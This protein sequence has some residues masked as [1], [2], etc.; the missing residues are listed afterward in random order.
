MYNSLNDTWSHLGYIMKTSFSLLFIPFL[1][2]LSIFLMTA[3]GQNIS[4][5]TITGPGQET[6]TGQMTLPDVSVVQLTQGEKLAVV[7]TTSIIG[8]VVAKVGGAAIQL[9]VLMEAGQDPHSF[10]PAPQD[11]AAIED[12]D[13]VFVNGLD[14]EEVLMESIRDITSGWVVPVS[15]G[16]KLLEIGED[17]HEGE[18]HIEEINIETK[19]FRGDPH[20][21][22]DPNNVMVW[23]QNI[24]KMLT[25][26]DPGNSE[27]YKA[28]ADAYLVELKTLDR[29][30]REQTTSIPEENRKLITDHHVLAYFTNEYG[31]KLIGAVIPSTSNTAGASAG[32]VARLVEVIENEGIRVIFIGTTAGSGMQNLAGALADEV[33]AEVK[34]VPIQTGSLA[35][36][37]EY[38]DTYLDY[39]RY[40]IDQIVSG[41]TQ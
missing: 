11:L 39:M 18:D 27:S 10:E 7:A 41:L 24:E 17:N 4:A 30:I 35:P 29:Y 33:G 23:V 6:D 32:D 19:N 40:N 13:L 26:G 25:Q 1:L 3:C 22:S 8:D 15:A 9:T 37:G 2:V 14:L 28:N 5:N 21:W 31:Y 16:I 38:G 34:I 36:A 20:F 12:A